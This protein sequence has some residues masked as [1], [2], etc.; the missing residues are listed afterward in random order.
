MEYLHNKKL[1]DQG[2]IAVR[3]W[4]VKSV[5]YVCSHTVTEAHSTLELKELVLGKRR[6]RPALRQLVEQNQVI[7]LR[8]P[9]L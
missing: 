4:S 8:L 3:D 5:R 9:H 7:S 2:L 6:S 1:S